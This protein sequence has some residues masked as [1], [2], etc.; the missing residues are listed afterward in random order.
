MIHDWLAMRKEMIWACRLQN[1]CLTFVV[2]PF[3]TAMMRME[4]KRIEGVPLLRLFIKS[5]QIDYL[6]FS[7]GFQTDFGGNAQAM[8][9]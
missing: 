4:S 3:Q 7:L 9:N 8:A 1:G 6:F 2:T 5:C